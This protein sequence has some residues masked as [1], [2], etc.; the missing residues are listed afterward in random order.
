ME[1]EEAKTEIIEPPV[2]VSPY[3][4]NIKEK[5]QV[6]CRYDVEAWYEILKEFTFPT[7]FLPLSIPE[8][9]AIRSLYKHRFLHGEKLNEKDAEIEALKQS[10]AELKQEMHS[11]AGRK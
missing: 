1:K 7:S 4:Q 10:V 8:A 9:K 5:L 3:H 2:S 6:E 11:L